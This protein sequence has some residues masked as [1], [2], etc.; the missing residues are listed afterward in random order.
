MQL[1]SGI[2]VLL[3]PYYTP[4]KLVSMGYFLFAKGIPK[5][6]FKC[7][8]IIFRNVLGMEKNIYQKILL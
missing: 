1:N 6:R 4:P 5:N 7:S 2:N 3:L 8:T